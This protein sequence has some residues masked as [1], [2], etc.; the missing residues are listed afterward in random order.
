MNIHT[1][2]VAIGTRDTDS[3]HVKWLQNDIDLFV[4]L[5]SQ[6]K[7]NTESIDIFCI[8]GSTDAFLY[9]KMNTK[10]DVWIFANAIWSSSIKLTMP[11]AGNTKKKNYAEKKKTHTLIFLPWNVCPN[12]PNRMRIPSF[13]WPIH[14]KIT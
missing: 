8:N 13:I 6:S 4:C 11:A 9:K 3:M 5:S 12:I 10:S 2:Y 14:S 7:R 1:R